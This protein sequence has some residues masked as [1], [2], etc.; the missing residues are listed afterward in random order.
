[1]RI[2]GL[3]VLLL[4]ATWMLLVVAAHLSAAQALDAQ[5]PDSLGS[6]R[7][8]VVRRYPPHPTT[9]AGRHLI[10]MAAGVGVQLA[11][12]G[13]EVLATPNS[14]ELNDIVGNFVYAQFV[15]A[16]DAVDAPP[17]EIETFI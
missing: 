8:D 1:M 14:L 16:D 13:E 12:K 10:E 3:I 15:K 2:V 9:G 17:P 7:N 11:E 6:L 4:L 5:W